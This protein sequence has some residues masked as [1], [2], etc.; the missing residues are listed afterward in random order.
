MPFELFIERKS[1]LS[2]EPLILLDLL[3]HIGILQ[4]VSL[5]IQAVH[6]V[7]PPPPS[8]AL[9]RPITQI[10]HVDLPPS[11][12]SAARDNLALVIQRH[13]LCQ[14]IELLCIIE[15][16]SVSEGTASVPI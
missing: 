10:F 4:D 7:L 1:Y 12:S 14:I 15:L 13:H 8:T 5:P 16:T 6:Q 11:L 2:F 9:I 3:N